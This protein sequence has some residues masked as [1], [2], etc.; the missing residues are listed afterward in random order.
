MSVSPLSHKSRKAVPVQQPDLI[1]LNGDVIPMS[2]ATVGVE[3]RGYQFADGVY[4]VIRIYN[5]RPFTLREHM[6]RL[7]RSADGIRMPL[8]LS[9]A[10]IGREIANFLPRTDVR[11]G[12]IYL[13]A[14]RGVSPRNHVFP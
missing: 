14:T 8:P 1:W 9:T 13:Q 5:G 7:G 4:E 6:E 12:M 3:D 2:D 10:D 11:D